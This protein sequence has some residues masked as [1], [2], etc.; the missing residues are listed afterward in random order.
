[1]EAFHEVKRNEADVILTPTWL[2][3]VTNG[4]LCYRVCCRPLGR[5]VQWSKDELYCP[6]PSSMTSKLTLVRANLKRHA[7]RFFDISRAFLRTPVKRKVFLKPPVEYR[8]ETEE[9]VW[10]LDKVMYGLEEA[11]DEFD[12]Y[13]EEV[14]TGQVKDPANP[15]S[16]SEVLNFE[17]MVCEPAVFVN[18]AWDVVISKHVDDGLVTGP[19]DKVEAVLR[20]LGQLFFLKVAPELQT[21]QETMY[22]GRVLTKIEGGFAYR[23]SAKLINNF[24][25]AFNLTKAS[26]VRAP[27]I[28][29]GDATR[30]R[31][32]A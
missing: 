19:P 15:T 32:G 1:L 29:Q 28:K 3:T 10:Q 4:K 21:G 12:D 20:A 27:C 17:R 9:R 23:P 13:F 16:K 18:K 14:V 7:V 31:K 6:M 5:K 22:R 30:K 24:L 26:A 11:M 8:P 25:E 2:Q